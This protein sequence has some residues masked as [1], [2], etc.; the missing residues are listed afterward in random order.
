[1]VA[2]PHVLKLLDVLTDV[3][4]HGI[5]ARRVWAYVTILLHAS[6]KKLQ[7]MYMVSAHD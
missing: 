5:I 1:M 6:S 2:V 3:F 4:S 7:A